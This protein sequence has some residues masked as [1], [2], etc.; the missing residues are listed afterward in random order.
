M[1]HADPSDQ[2]RS[3]TGPNSPKY[4]NPG[5]RRKATLPGCKSDDDVR[6]QLIEN[7]GH[8]LQGAV[9]APQ[10]LRVRKC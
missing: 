8:L 10:S 4:P 2:N 6:E 1:T 9:Y 5:N 3:A 7:A